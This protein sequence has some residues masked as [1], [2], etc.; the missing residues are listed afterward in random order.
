MRSV[1]PITLTGHTAAVYALAS[2]RG[3]FLSGD[4]DGLVAYW[5]PDAD[6]GRD[7]RA[8]AR[9]DDRVFALLP[10]ARHADDRRRDSLAVGT[11]TGDLY[12]VDA[13]AA[14]APRRWRFHADGTFALLQLPPAPGGGAG[15]DLLV[16]GGKG[17]LSRWPPDGTG[18]RSH[19]V[20]DAGVRVRSLC[21]LPGPGLVAAGTGAGDVHLLAPDSLRTVHVVE[22]A[23]ELTVFSLADAGDRFYS[24]GRDGKIRAWSTEA[25]FRQLAHVDAHAATV[26]ALAYD[27]VSGVLASA[28]R[29]REVR[30]WR[31]GERG[32]VLAK[33]LVAGRDGG[34]AASV[35]ACVWGGGY[36]TTGSDDRT[37]RAWRADDILGESSA[38]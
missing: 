12:F 4:G 33:A 14:H 3:G 15:G 23:H 9:L 25:P 36:L 28:G 2:W 29:D 34:H 5:E 1:S 37:L 16:G 17:L 27:V 8:V 31:Q 10:L 7:G 24:A 18:M 26:N 30:L 35:N 21:Y 20:L 13:T 32:L 22:R 11:L 38:G 19:V 6:D